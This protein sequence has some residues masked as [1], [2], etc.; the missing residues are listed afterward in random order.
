MTQS[1]LG[2]H[3]GV[4]QTAIANYE[5]GTRSPGAE[6]LHKIATV[7]QI[8]VDELLGRSQDR[9]LSTILDGIPYPFKTYESADK[10][11]IPYETETY[12]KLALS[13]RPVEAVNRV[14]SLADL[15][16]PTNTIYRNILESVISQSTKMTGAKKMTIHQE[17]SLIQSITSCMGLL[18]ER[19]IC[20]PSNGKRFLGI[21]MGFDRH[22]IGLMMICD[23]MHMEGWD[24]I[25]LKDY[26][27]D[28]QAP[29]IINSFK[30]D[31]L[32]ISVTLLESIP[33]VEQ[34]IS[35]LKDSNKDFFVVVG[36]QALSSDPKLWQKLNADAYAP[37]GIKA[38]SLLATL[39]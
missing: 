34:L 10:I 32:G 31:V 9:L 22:N 8:T 33:Q 5:N 15:G 16:V 26:V 23:Y 20:K 17:F 24:V 27:P 19:L 37:D 38:A 18:Q 3:L 11:D 30:P 39:I 2:G 21:T 14:V 12:I 13:G 4:G 25:C 36:G 28:R 1:E 7:L 35:S 29:D 6:G